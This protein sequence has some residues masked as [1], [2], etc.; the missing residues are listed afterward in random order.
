MTMF[1][2]SFVFLL[3]LLHSN[4]V[5]LLVHLFDRWLLPR[6]ESAVKAVLQ[7]RKNGVGLLLKINLV[8]TYVML[9]QQREA[10]QQLCLAFISD[11]VDAWQ[12]L[13]SNHNWEFIWNNRLSLMIYQEFCL[14]WKPPVVTFIVT[15]FQNFNRFNDNNRSQWLKHIEQF[16]S[17]WFCSFYGHWMFKRQNE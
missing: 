4:W 9:W 10:M 11:E 5:M 8:K 16:E 6:L 7:L 1:N 2:N 3:L 12:I 14:L 13:H 17:N 15:S